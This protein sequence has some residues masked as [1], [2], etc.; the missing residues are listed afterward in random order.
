ME[1]D[2]QSAYQAE[3]EA[4]ASLV[5]EQ[6]ELLKTFESDGKSALTPEGQERFDKIEADIAEKRA[7]LEKLRRV[8]ENQ[9]AAESE[10]RWLE[11]SAG[12][13]TQPSDPAEKR[14][15][16]RRAAGENRETRYKIGDYNAPLVAG[17]GH[18][19]T[20]EYRSAFGSYLKGRR[21]SD[22]EQ[23]A[24]S[25]GTEAEGGATVPVAMANVI[26]EDMKEMSVTR[27][28]SRNIFD[29][30]GKGIELPRVD[31][32]PAIGGAPQTEITNEELDIDFDS[33]LLNPYTFRKLLR[34]SDRLLRADSGI[35]IEGEANRLMAEALVEEEERFALTGSGSG[36]PLGI[37]TADA[38]GITTT[39]DHRAASATAIATSD[40]I[41]FIHAL[42]AKYRQRSR[43]TH[44]VATSTFTEAVRLLDDGNGRFLWMPSLALGMPETLAGIPYH[45]QPLAEPGT[46]GTLAIDEYHAVVGDFS[47]YV[48]VTGL[49]LRVKVLRERYAETGQVG[50]LFEH[51]VTSQPL[52]ANAFRRFQMAAA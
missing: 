4:V 16:E 47:N 49:N 2:V 26:F 7:K 32:K 23:R 30:S 24:L 46:Q 40:V 9:D 52:V 34:I 50:Y 41:S 13:A 42:P 17:R 51:E 14:S 3:A 10:A 5:G 29:Q 21:L 22:E 28:I 39:Q 20:E 43:N 38:A 19:G 15:G 33:P 45:E 8:A 35:D 36:Q 11:R 44:V 12:R 27:R 6:R 25:A 31:T 37:F 48:F 18:L 1:Y